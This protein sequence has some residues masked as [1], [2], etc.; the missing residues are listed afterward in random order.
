MEYNIVSKV[1]IPAS[2]ET[3]LKSL[4]TAI[5]TFVENNDGTVSFMIRTVEPVE[6]PE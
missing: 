4:L 2:D 3:E 1:Q 6:E 5:E